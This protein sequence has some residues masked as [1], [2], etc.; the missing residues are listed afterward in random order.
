MFADLLGEGTAVL[1]LRCFCPNWNGTTLARH[2]T[3][4]QAKCKQLWIALCGFY[5]LKSFCAALENENKN[6]GFPISSPGAESSPPSPHP[7]PNSSVH[8]QGKVVCLVSLVSA[9]TPWSPSIW[10]SVSIS[11]TWFCFES[12]NPEDSCSTNVC[13]SSWGRKGLTS[14]APWWAP[15]ES[16]SQTMP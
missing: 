4:T 7:H 13:C 1:I 11:G 5:F 8:S 12:P 15:L 10:L 16:G 14:A 3:L 6:G 2:L 9:R